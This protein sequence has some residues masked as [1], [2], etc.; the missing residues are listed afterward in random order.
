VNETQNIIN[1][2]EEYLRQEKQTGQRC[3]GSIQFLRRRLAWLSSGDLE[4]EEVR[5]EARVH[6]DF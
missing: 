5:K 1:F 4:W 6:V 2:Q 3:W